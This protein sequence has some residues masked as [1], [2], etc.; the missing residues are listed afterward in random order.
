MNDLKEN[1]L[2]HDDSSFVMM[3]HIYDSLCCNKGLKLASCVVTKND[4]SSLTKK[5]RGVMTHLLLMTHF[6]DSS[7]RNK[8]FKL[9]SYLVTIYILYYI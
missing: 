2:E 5:Q 4:D 7:C 6:Y 1:V 9:A 8:R 3:T